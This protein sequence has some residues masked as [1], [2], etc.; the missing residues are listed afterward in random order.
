MTN[1]E[2]NTSLDYS[3]YVVTILML[4]YVSSFVDRQIL[5]LLVVPMKRD[6]DLSDFQM[7]LL[8]GFSFALFYTFL[9]IPIGWLA[10]HKNRR[11]III[12][13]IGIWSVMTAFGAVA[14]NFG[15]FFVTR[16]GVGVGESTLSPSAYSMIGDYFPKDKLATAFGIYSMGIYIGTGIAIVIGGLL[17]RLSGDGTVWEIPLIG[18][19]Y[20]WQSVFL[21]I[22]IPGLIIMLLMLTVKEPAR[23]GLSKHNFSILH[24]LKVLK[25]Q[26]SFILISI[27]TGLY[28]V[29]AYSFSMWTPTFF[30]R[31]YG[32]D[33]S[34][35][36]LGYGL[37]FAIFCTIGT[38]LSG[39]FSDSLYKK[40]YH[41]A[42]PRTALFS[43]L[44]LFISAIFFTM[45]PSE[46]LAMIFTIPVNFFIGAT[47]TPASA[48]TQEVLPT[49]MRSLGSAVFLFILNLIGLG[50][51]PTITAMFTDYVFQDESML[52]YSLL[53]VGSLFPVGS[54]IFY[55]LSLKNY[56]H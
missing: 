25:N 34:Q 16:L 43:V 48:S 12:W 44:G 56:T 40:G 31:T 45:M 47:I 27:A 10:D 37:S 14:K 7:S 55:Y 24:S 20:P 18:E 50:M 53:V 13:G 39:R 22:G 1:S 52:Q 36:S 21:M 28:T 54:A 11:N 2:N 26:H 41:D 33:V 32:S 4:A 29:V 9:G 23:K 8:M 35:I 49:N 42:K 15:Q 38:L 46:E 19:I 3:W 30:V 51:G 17:L 6:L 5:S